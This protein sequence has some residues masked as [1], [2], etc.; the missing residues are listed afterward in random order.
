MDKIW[1]YLGLVDTLVHGHMFSEKQ[2]IKR[3]N[4]FF[5]KLLHIETR[6]VQ[7]INTNLP[8]T[9]YLYK[10]YHVIDVLLQT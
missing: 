6:I 10:L 2:M 4:K 1:L 3:S 8:Q 9:V 7:G 5:L